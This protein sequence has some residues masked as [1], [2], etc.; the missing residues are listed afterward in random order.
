MRSLFSNRYGNKRRDFYERYE[1][2][3]KL[4]PSLPLYERPREPAEL[5]VF[6]QQTTNRRRYLSYRQMANQS[7]E[8][9]DNDTWLSSHLLPIVVRRN[10]EGR[11]RRLRM[12]R[13]NPAAATHE[14]SHN[15]KPRRGRPPTAATVA[16]FASDFAV[17]VGGFRI[18]EDDSESP[19]SSS[20]S[21]SSSEEEEEAMEME[22]VKEL[23]QF[24]KDSED[25]ENM[26]SMIDSK[27]SNRNLNG[28]ENVNQQ[29]NNL[30]HNMNQQVNRNF[31]QNFN[32][33][34]IRNFYHNFIPDLNQNFNQNSN[35]SPNSSQLLPRNSNQNLFFVQ[36]PNQLQA[37]YQAPFTDDD[38]ENTPSMLAVSPTS[39]SFICPIES[40]KQIFGLRRALY[41][42][43]R[44]EG[45]HNWSHKCGQCGQIFRT[46]G[47]KR[48]HSSK[49]CERN[50]LKFRISK[51][52]EIKQLLRRTM[53]E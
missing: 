3:R 16:K 31:N 21:S 40:C 34:R 48:M 50:L 45:H 5:Q 6:N 7:R 19:S 44:E 12:P 9:L 47:F 32:R 2:A 51:P 23:E 28:N 10:I 29:A 41:K 42:H 11:N 20:S 14:F 43:Q 30:N 8:Q 35:D 38:E 49:A 27:N 36:H 25:K 24:S 37:Q 17:Q 1:A 26:G 4:H 18:S 13:F 33:N 15:G 53:P 39:R 46:A 52:N 22:M